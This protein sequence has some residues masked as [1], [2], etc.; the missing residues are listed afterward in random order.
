[1]P[2]FTTPSLNQLD[3]D[4]PGPLL[5]FSMQLLSSVKRLSTLWSSGPSPSGSTV[6]I[7]T[8]FPILQGECATWCQR[9]WSAGSCLVLSD[10]PEFPGSA[11]PEGEHP[12]KWKPLMFKKHLE[13]YIFFY[14]IGNIKCTI[15]A[16]FIIWFEYC[17]FI[18]LYHTV[19]H[20]ILKCHS[21]LL[22]LINSRKLFRHV[23]PLKK[24]CRQALTVY[25]TNVTSMQIRPASKVLSYT[26]LFLP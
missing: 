19:K 9:L 16:Y 12:G 10:F 4:L 7:L 24:H 17:I 1:M 21:S 11:D 15:I 3:W 5:R 25:I 18:N 22:F 26:S 2:P 13:K 14:Y 6:W 8:H 23:F 20:K